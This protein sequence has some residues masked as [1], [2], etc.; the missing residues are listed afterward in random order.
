M[1]RADSG[2]LIV[3]GDSANTN[4]RTLLAKSLATQGFSNIEPM[5]CRE[6]AT[7]VETIQGSTGMARFVA[8]LDFASKCMTGTENAKLKQAVQARASGGRRGQKKFGDLFPITDKMIQSGSDEAILA[9]LTAMRNRPET[10]L[11]RRE[12]FYAMA[13][14]LKIKVARKRESLPE[15]VVEV[16]NQ[17]RHSGRRLAKRSIGSIL[18]VKGLEFD[19]SVIIH[20]AKMSRKDWYV[21]LTRASKSICVISPSERITITT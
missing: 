15:V 17:I 10:Y 11:Y 3:I 6:L 4:A 19:H 14:A 16:Q 21:A 18:L 5:D 2:S 12:M 9:F 20:T 13:A 7:T 8:V 1:D